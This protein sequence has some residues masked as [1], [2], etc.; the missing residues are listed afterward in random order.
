M[1]LKYNK[2]ILSKIFTKASYHTKTLI[3]SLTTIL[4]GISGGYI[5]IKSKNNLETTKKQQAETQINQ[6]KKNE[7]NIQA[8]YEK[9]SN[10]IEYIESERIE[11]LESYW[12]FKNTIFHIKLANK[13]KSTHDYDKVINELVKVN[14]LNDG[15]AQI[16]TQL[17]T[18]NQDLV[19]YLATNPKIDN[20]IFPNAPPSVLQDL[21]KFKKKND[22]L[23]KKSLVDDDDFN[24]IFD[25]YMNKIAKLHLEK[26]STPA[27]IKFYVKKFFSA[28][29][30]LL[31][32]D[33]KL[34]SRYTILDDLTILHDNDFIED[35]EHVLSEEYGD[36]ASVSFTKH[37]FLTSL[38]YL[39]L[40]ILD[41]YAMLNQ[42]DFIKF[43]GI[44]ILLILYEKNKFNMKF[45]M[46]IFDILSILSLNSDNRKLFIKSGWIRRIHELVVKL[47]TDLNTVNLM[48]NLL[49]NKLTVENYYKCLEKNLI[50]KL[51]VYKI[52]FNLKSS[53][54]ILYS[55]MIYPLY[56][57]KNVENNLNM[58]S[59]VT[60]L[61]DAMH[62][63]K[64]AGSGGDESIDVVFIHGLLGWVSQ[65]S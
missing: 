28:F 46:P 41:S 64:F 14:N 32:H 37:E 13:T 17:I 2:K 59:I 19:L 21:L 25:F 44:D 35:D 61:Q 58:E 30:S 23:G 27:N 3:I 40:Q 48:T 31:M 55:N 11:N 10:K 15:L 38:E 8:L 53:N 49:F 29:N 1:K 26:T 39:I 34:K 43:G 7:I 18:D 24:F 52:M 63:E 36:N 57:L 42:A 50:L 65:S 54:K 16:I 9:Y 47:N 4:A 45:L 62:A 6:I 33:Y 51:I 60:N 22:Q 20:R 56:P 5:I 12:R